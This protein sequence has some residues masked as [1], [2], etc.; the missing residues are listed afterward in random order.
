MS[1]LLEWASISPLYFPLIRFDAFYSDKATQHDIYMGSVQP[2]L[3]HL[4]EGQNASIL[5]YG[6][7]G[8]GE[9]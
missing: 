9:F 2:V 7:T 6:P 3:G 8:A 5:A 4:L 1:L